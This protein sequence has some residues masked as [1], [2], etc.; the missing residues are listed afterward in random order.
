[1]VP[2]P[3]GQGSEGEVQGAEDLRPE[4]GGGEEVTVTQA[5]S[6]ATVWR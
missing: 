3:S 4:G 1:M 5:E 2:G 6:C